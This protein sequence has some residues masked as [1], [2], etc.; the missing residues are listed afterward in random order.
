MRAS[1]PPREVWK[2]SAIFASVS[3]CGQLG[4]RGLGAEEV[5]ADVGG[6]AGGVRLELRVGDLAQAADQRARGVELEQL[7]PGA[8]PTAT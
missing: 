5:L 2:H 4:E 1:W 8:R 7:V 6:V 3:S